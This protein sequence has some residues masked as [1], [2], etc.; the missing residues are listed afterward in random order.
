MRVAIP[1]TEANSG[2]IKATGANNAAFALLLG[3]NSADPVDATVVIP[4][5]NDPDDN[6]VTITLG[7]NRWA[8]GNQY[9]VVVV[10]RIN[11]NGG[12]GISVDGKTITIFENRASPRL[13]DIKSV[14]DKFGG[15]YNLTLAL[16][17]TASTGIVYKS[18]T[19]SGGKDPVPA[20][21]RTVELR[22]PS[23]KYMGI[24]KQKGSTAPATAT[25]PQDR[26]W[27]SQGPMYIGLAGDESLY[28]KNM[29]T[30]TDTAA[31]DVSVREYLGSDIKD[32]T[33]QGL[34]L[35]VA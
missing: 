21:Y 20:K 15:P 18:Y 13:T 12:D 10:R 28:A 8:S 24:I 9:E 16:S 1:F 23:S 22:W 26:K 31:F 25:A 3:P 17:G 29:R 14:I 11:S 27:G 30:T 32:F 33:P 34:T 4:G 7:G 6:Y 19:P 5:R 35:R 2:G